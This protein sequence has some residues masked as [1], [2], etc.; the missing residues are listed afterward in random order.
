MLEEI[1]RQEYIYKGYEIKVTSFRR[2]ADGVPKADI[3]IYNSEGRIE[4]R[5]NRIRQ[6][7]K[8]T[9]FSM[10]GTRIDIYI[11]QPL[12]FGDEPDMLENYRNELILRE[13]TKYCNY[14]A[15]LEWS[16]LQSASLPDSLRAI[17][18]SR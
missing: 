4:G 15:H 5:L 18:L 11:F 13:G 17:E 6:F 2:D 16:S 8:A 7:E 14:T 9:W 3:E 12:Q 1:R 10:N